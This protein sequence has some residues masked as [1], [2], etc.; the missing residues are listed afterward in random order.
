MRDHSKQN[1]DANNAIGLAPEG[2]TPPC[3]GQTADAKFCIASRKN[4][5]RIRTGVFFGG[6]AV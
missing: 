2:L 1:I 5:G 4:A 3:L 6:M